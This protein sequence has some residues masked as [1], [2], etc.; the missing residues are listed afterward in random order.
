MRGEDREKE[1]EEVPAGEQMLFL[2]VGMRMQ[3]QSAVA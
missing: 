2:C 1:E 3:Q